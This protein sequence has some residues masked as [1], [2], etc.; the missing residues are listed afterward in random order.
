M[1]VH[2]PLFFLEYIV[3][4]GLELGFRGSVLDVDKWILEGGNAKVGLEGG[5]EFEGD[6]TSGPHSPTVESWDVIA[7]RGVSLV[8]INTVVPIINVE[9]PGAQIGGEAG[10]LVAPFEIA[11]PSEVYII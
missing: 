11:H 2:Q 8:D 7:A 9:N 4:L 10:V 5:G 6:G 3:Q 1:V